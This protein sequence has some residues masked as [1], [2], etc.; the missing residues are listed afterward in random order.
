[1][2][3]HDF[4]FLLIQGKDWPY[5]S[6]QGDFSEQVMYQLY[7]RW[8]ETWHLPRCIALTC[9]NWKK[10]KS[11]LIASEVCTHNIRGIVFIANVLTSL[12]TEG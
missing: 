7:E 9:I 5:V 6:V 10:G 3:S 1:M 11:N 2:I 8:K 4:L 12:L